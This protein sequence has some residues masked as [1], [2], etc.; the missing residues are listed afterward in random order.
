MS[1]TP[2]EQLKREA[3]A[4]LQYHPDDIRAVSAAPC[5]DCGVADPFMYPCHQQGCPHQ[6]AQMSGADLQHPDYCTIC[7]GAHWFECD[8]RDDLS[9]LDDGVPIPGRTRKRP[10]PKPADEIAAIRAKAWA[11]RRQRYGSAGHK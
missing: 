11:T 2:I 7:G 9:G 4:G 5:T 6:H 10:E 1:A 8:H 3:L